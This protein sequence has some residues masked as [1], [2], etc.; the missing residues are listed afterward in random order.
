MRKLETHCE[1]ERPQDAKLHV[2]AQIPQ[3]R[4]WRDAADLV[5]VRQAVHD[6]VPVV[7]EQKARQDVGAHLGEGHV[8][9]GDAHHADN[10]DH[11]CHGRPE[12][13]EA[14]TPKA[15]QIHVARAVELAQDGVGHQVARQH[16][17]HDDAHV[18]ARQPVHLQVVCHHGCDRQGAQALD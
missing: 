6:V 17:E 11:R 2:N 14:A 5:E 16:E 18:A 9:E 12:T 7:E 15:R 8:V 1:D 13:L 4:E 10:E 3:V